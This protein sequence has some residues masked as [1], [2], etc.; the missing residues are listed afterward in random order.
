M[1]RPSAFETDLKA[2]LKKYHKSAR[3]IESVI[4][5][6]EKKPDVGDRYPGFGSI[7][8]RKMRIPL[9][10]Y[11]IG[12]S[13]GLRLLFVVKPEKPEIF[14]LTIYMKNKHKS[15][16]DVVKT[17]IERLDKIETELDI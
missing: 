9:P 14:L 11:N 10:E 6:L 12:K 16:T 8:V 4:R 15:E 1:L 2:V 3:R 7:E 5:D 13:D 17:I